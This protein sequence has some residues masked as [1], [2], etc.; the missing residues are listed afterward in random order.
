MWN[1]GQNETSLYFC[2]KQVLKLVSYF[3]MKQVLKEGC[4]VLPHFPHSP[5]SPYPP[6]KGF[7]RFCQ[8]TVFMT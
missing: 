5:I 1:M 6:G 8:G 2:M 4:F 7:L 3:C